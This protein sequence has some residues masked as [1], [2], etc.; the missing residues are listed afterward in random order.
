LLTPTGVWNAVFGIYQ[1]LTP[2]V[3]MDVTQVSEEERRA[4]DQWRDEYEGRWRRNFDPI[5]IRITLDENTMASDVTV[6]PINV[7]T[8]REFA[9]LL[10]FSTGVKF[11]PDQSVY[12]TPLQFIISI[13]PESQQFRSNANLAEQL[14]GGVSLGWIGN[15]ATVF[16]EDAPFWQEMLDSLEKDQWGYFSWLF[17]EGNINRL[18]VGVEVA[19]NNPLKLA[20]FLTGLRGMV[21]QSAPGLTQWE[22]LNYR[23]VPYV[24]ISPRDDDGMMGIPDSFA[25]YYTPANGRLFVTLSEGVLKRHIDRRLD[26]Q[27]ESQPAK[28]S[29]ENMALR[30][31]ERAVPVLDRLYML[32]MP[33]KMTDSAWWNVS[34]LEEYKRR[35]PDKD[36]IEVHEQLWGE[37]LFCPNNGSYVWNETWQTFE[38]QLGELPNTSPIAAIQNADLGVT[39]ENDGIRARVQLELK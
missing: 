35:F 39:F 9:Q 37:R 25:I 13:N 26:K 18:P 8:N 31:D 23:D 30:L 6:M 20:A 10:G 14:A 12:G 16:F 15:H 36:P 38:P 29:G 2:I 1:F 27:P 3:E 21:E 17:E 19:S 22:A 11:S 28:W 5:G 32:E 4:Y 7:R 24:K 33:E 34:I